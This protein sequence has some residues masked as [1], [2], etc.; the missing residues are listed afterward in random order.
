MTKILTPVQ[1][2][3]LEVSGN[4]LESPVE[5]I[6]YQHTVFC[7]T[8]L[9][10][11]NP[12]ERRIWERQQGAVYLRIEAGAGSQSER[13]KVYRCWFAVWLKASSNFSAP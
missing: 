9:P 8:C 10:Y 7:Q 6:A 4:I 1:T 11:K 5:Q 12:G 3:R 13:E 2:R